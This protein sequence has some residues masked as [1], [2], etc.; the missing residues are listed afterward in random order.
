MSGKILVTGAG[1]TV[2]SEVV[3]TLCN[4]GKAVRAAIRNTGKMSAAVGDRVESRPFDFYDESTYAPLFDDIEGLFLLTPPVGLPERKM[5]IALI[6][7]ARENGVRHIVRLSAMGVENNDD[8]HHRQVEK[9]LEKSG[10]TF[11]IL[12]PN[13]FMQNFISY[14]QGCIKNQN[15]IVLPAGSG[16]TSFVDVRDIAAATAKIFFNDEHLNKSYTLTGPA[17][18]DHFGVAETLS[19]VLGRE[20]TYTPVSDE[21]MRDHLME[22]AWVN[23]EIEDFIKM[24]QCVQ[25]GWSAVVSPDLPAILNC[26][27]RSFADFAHDHA[28]A[29]R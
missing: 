22:L 14:Y 8:S 25:I 5:A 13:F 17:A 16:K 28:D 21:Q 27:P 7:A 15:R 18:I 12:R 1:G 6:E 4:A 20:I 3:K 29:W 24:Y 11:T 23:E 9:Y 26:P 10:V 19:S 2:G